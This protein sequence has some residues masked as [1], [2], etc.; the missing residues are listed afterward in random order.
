MRQSS[1]IFESA[2]VNVA[3]T[4]VKKEREVK[5]C[6]VV[7]VPWIDGDFRCYVEKNKFLYSQSDLDFQPWTLVSPRILCVR[8]KIEEAGTSLEQLQ[9][10]IR[11]G[12]ATGDNDVFI[13][14][15]ERRSQL[16]ALDKK[17]SE[18]I[19]PVLRGQDI[20]RYNHK[21]V[22]YI[23]LTKNGVNV[24]RE[25]PTL[26][27][28]FK[29]F[30]EKFKNRG[31]RGKHWTNLRACAFFD[32]FLKEK[33][34][35]IELTDNGRF[36]YSSSEEYL[37]NSA[38]FLIPP[39]EVDVK[40]LLGIL[41]SKLIQIY[42]SFI[43]ATSGMG[44]LRWINNYVKQFPIPI[45]DWD[46]QMRISELVHKILEIKNLNPLS[47]TIDLELEIDK[48]VFHLYNLTYDEVLLIDSKTPITREGYE[49]C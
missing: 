12:L 47:K 1:Q 41:N 4:I 15:E 46:I 31:A 3:I 42:M 32:D 19:K 25:F 40:F 22:K 5:K 43:A 26:Y 18:V 30:G 38:Y 44:T 23:I 8:K 24:P 20:K 16:I 6:V 48:I 39:K 29:S 14:D 27:E 33:I 17:N 34:I 45:V 36:S 9:T 49:N 2:I 28:Y 21:A 37:L 11:L 10:K 35:W 7:N 13:I